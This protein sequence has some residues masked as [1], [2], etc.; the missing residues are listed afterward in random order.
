MNV[1]VCGTP[2]MNQTFEETFEQLRKEGKV[3]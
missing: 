3:D 2:S 1:W